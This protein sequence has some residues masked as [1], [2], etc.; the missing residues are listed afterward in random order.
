MPPTSRFLIDDLLYTPLLTSTLREP[1][2]FQAAIAKGAC[3]A[4]ASSALRVLPRPR[5]AASS[6]L[7]AALNF[8]PVEEGD[9]QAQ[10]WLLC[11]SEQG[12]LFTEMGAAS[13]CTGCPVPLMAEA[14]LHS[15]SGV[16][17]AAS[18]GL[19]SMALA[20]SRQLH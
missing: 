6:S 20:A 10:R 15:T 18:S 17:A 5:A 19:H 2:P 4:Q 3:A 13:I 9:Q 1:L 7:Y 8:Q 11:D 16:T 12:C 14:L